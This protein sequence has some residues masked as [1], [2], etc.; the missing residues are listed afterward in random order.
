MGIGHTKNVQRLTRRC[1]SPCALMKLSEETRIRADGRRG[2]SGARAGIDTAR[3]EMAR[4]V[5]SGNGIT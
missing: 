5:F 4:I 3:L 2:P 1:L